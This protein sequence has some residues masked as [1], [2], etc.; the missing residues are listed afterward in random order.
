MKMPIVGEKEPGGVAAFYVT[1]ISST[2]KT[3]VFY[4]TNDGHL[5]AEKATIK[6]AILTDEGSSLGGWS[7]N[8]E[9]LTATDENENV[10]VKWYIH[11][12]EDH[13]GT[14]YGYT[15]RS[16][17]LSVTETIKITLTP[18]RVEVYEAYII[19]TTIDG[20]NKDKDWLYD[21]DYYYEGRTKYYPGN[22]FVSYNRTRTWARIVRSD[23]DEGLTPG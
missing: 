4:V 12:L 6:G 14:E 19:P 11:S 18:T 20:F 3:P 2:K 17:T 23:P 5:Y 10:E 7:V 22:E 8:A 1:K 21:N 9:H 13:N 16:V 15:K